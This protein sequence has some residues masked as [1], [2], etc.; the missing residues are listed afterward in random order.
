MELS[1]ENIV[2]AGPPAVTKQRNLAKEKAF[3][4]M[5]KYVKEALS[6]A[7]EVIRIYHLEKLRTTIA[8]RT[9]NG[10][11]RMAHA[12][13]NPTDVYN[14]TIGNYLAVKR[15]RGGKI[16]KSILPYI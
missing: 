3:A 11:E 10:E 12:T 13:C 5:A 1:T 6:T 15:V 8:L 9:A 7:N 16:P 2:D 14:R 4:L